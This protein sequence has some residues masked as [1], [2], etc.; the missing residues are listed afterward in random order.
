M[1]QHIRDE[2]LHELCVRSRSLAE[3]VAYIKP[4]ARTKEEAWLMLSP[5]FANLSVQDIEA[6]WIPPTE[7]PA[8]P[9]P[10]RWPLCLFTRKTTHP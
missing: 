1:Q 10:G 5:F 9:K 2:I 8:K 7:P 4:F 3:V 6:V